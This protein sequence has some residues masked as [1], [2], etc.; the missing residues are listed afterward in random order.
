MAKEKH[1]SAIKLSRSDQIF[2]VCNYI[3]WAFIL[4]IVIYP[5]YFV[6]FSNNL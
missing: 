5:L 1:G 6:S 4:L 2:T 3:F